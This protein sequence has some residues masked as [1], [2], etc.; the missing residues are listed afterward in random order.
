MG[1]VGTETDEVERVEV[2]E[3][4]EPGFEASEVES[5]GRDDDMTGWSE[6]MMTNM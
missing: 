2:V 6:F 1:D 3:R 5:V 4:Y